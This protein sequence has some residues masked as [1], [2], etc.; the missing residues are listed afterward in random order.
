[1]SFGM[2]RALCTPMPSPMCTKNL[3]PA[4]M[5]AATNELPKT[6]PDALCPGLFSTA[7]LCTGSG[8]CTSTDDLF[9]TDS[10]GTGALFEC[11]DYFSTDCVSPDYFDTDRL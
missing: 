8:L 4:A 9:N 1:M 10:L 7:C 6:L 11:T 2:S 5:P 3:L